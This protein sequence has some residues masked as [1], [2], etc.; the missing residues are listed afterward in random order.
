MNPPFRT[1]FQPATLPSAK[2]SRK[3]LP[4]DKQVNYIDEYFIANNH[5]NKTFR[6]NEKNQS[7]EKKHAVLDGKVHAD[8]VIDLTNTLESSNDKI[9]DF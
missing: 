5:V 1:S 6:R 3:K 9:I 8:T 2:M 4:V 7:T